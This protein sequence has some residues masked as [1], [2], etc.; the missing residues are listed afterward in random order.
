MKA[1]IEDIINRF[2][3]RLPASKQ[4]RDAQLYLKSILEAFCNSVRVHEFKV[5]VNS[6][7]G[8]LKLFC[9]VFYISLVLYWY[10]PVA[11]L[12]LS[13]VNSILFVGHFA[14]YH[15]W[16]DFL[17]K[18]H[19]SL[20]IIGDVEPQEKAT[21][22]VIVSGHMDSTLEFIWWY[23]LKDIGMLFTV[24]SGLL[25]TFFPIVVAVALFAPSVATV[26]WWIF[27]VLSP[28]TIVYINI[29]GSRA[30]EG[31]QDNLSGI[32]VAT[33][34]GKYFA[35]NRLKN[36]RVRVLSFGCEEPGLRGSD[37]YAKAF[38]EQLH[39]ENAI[40]INVDNIRFPDKLTIISGEPMVL[41]R[42]PEKVIAPLESAF[43][44]L[45]IPYIKTMVP[46]GGTDAVSFDRQGIPAVTII[47]ISTEKLDPTYHTILDV[48]S[49]ID[50]VA[51]EHTR[52]V[53]VKFIKDHDSVKKG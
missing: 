12:A 21:S 49:S 41:A 39:S 9:S 11:A 14:I 50:P 19:D 48:P 8:S 43:K 22:T 36:T 16:L 1:L 32:T 52:D 45:S 10:H 51:L 30:I 33:E 4:E 24:L 44:S 46:I 47:G 29:H 53:I 34:V 17:F 15:H 40:C 26:L 38:K 2:G 20:N 28:I 35:Q 42:Y 6:M 25:I 23:R 37:A 7:F 27:A 13:L 31:A 5:P 3:P 18:K